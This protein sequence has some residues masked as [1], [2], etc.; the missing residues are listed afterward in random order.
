M[1]IPLTLTRK[2]GLSMPVE[3]FKKALEE[4]ANSSKEEPELEVTKKGA[5]YM[6]AVV[7]CVVK[8]VLQDAGNVC[9]QKKQRRLLPGHI[10][11]AVKRNDDLNELLGKCVE[12]FDTPIVLKA[13][14]NIEEEDES[15]SSS[16]DAS[17]D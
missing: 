17:D 6:T 1:D 15:S 12:K 10:I 14:K 13:K 11:E 4:H 2:A 3:K 7:E 8:N 5:I 9:R 16:S